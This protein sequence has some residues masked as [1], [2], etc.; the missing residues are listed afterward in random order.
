VSGGGYASAVVLYAG[1]KSEQTL[2]RQG[3][4]LMEVDREAI[5][6]NAVLNGLC[7]GLTKDQILRLAKNT[8]A[9]S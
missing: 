1:D 6:Y 9:D 8:T 2:D 4:F 5:L 7:C 3:D